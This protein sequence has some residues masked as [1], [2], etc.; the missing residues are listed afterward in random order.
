MSAM[1]KDSE[2]SAFKTQPESMTLLSM[3]P[4]QANLAPT[5]ICC[6]QSFH[7]TNPSQYSRD[8]TASLLYRVW[9]PPRI[10]KRLESTAKLPSAN[11]SL[12]PLFLWKTV[13]QKLTSLPFSKPGVGSSQKGKRVF[14]AMWHSN[15]VP[16]DLQG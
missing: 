12:S 9:R 11:W 7:R 16:I 1:I 13:R 10:G 2:N 6:A 4:S 3:C 8:S 15:F 14:F 5:R